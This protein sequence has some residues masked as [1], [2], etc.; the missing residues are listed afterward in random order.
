MEAP[1]TTSMVI[2]STKALLPNIQ[3]IICL[4]II[5]P[6]HKLQVLQVVHHSCRVPD[7]KV[8]T[9]DWRCFSARSIT[10]RS[11]KQ[12][13]GTYRPARPPSEWAAT[14]LVHRCIH[15]RGIRREY[16]QMDCWVYLSVSSCG[17]LVSRMPTHPVVRKEQGQCYMTSPITTA[18]RKVCEESVNEFGVKVFHYHI[19]DKNGLSK[20]N[21]CLGEG[22]AAAFSSILLIS[23]S[24]DPIVP[25]ARP[26]SSSILYPTREKLRRAS[27]AHLRTKGKPQ[28]LGASVQCASL[29]TGKHGAVFP[30]QSKGLKSA[31]RIVRDIGS[32]ETTCF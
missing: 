3:D 8:T 16:T 9:A 5:I 21:P 27:K 18:C 6:R 13:P 11:G 15:Y 29:Y 31:L 25:S 7:C 32:A 30:A 24:F 1:A 12:R 2:R 14:M 4:Y 20:K 26:S 28:R 23:N 22:C 19:T 17:F 10:S